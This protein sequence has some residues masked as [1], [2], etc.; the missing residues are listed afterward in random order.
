MQVLKHTIF[1][2]TLFFSVLTINTQAQCPDIYDYLGTPSASPE[3]F[4]CSGSNYT[5]NIQVSENVGAWTINWGDGSLI[6]SG[7][8]LNPSTLVSH[9]YGA[10]VATYD[11]TFTDIDDGCTVTGTLVMEEPSNATIQIPAGGITQSCAPQAMVFTNNSTNVSPNTVFTWDFGDGSDSET[12]DASNH[13]QTISHTYQSG[14][15]DCETVVTLTAQNLCNAVQGGPS[16]NTFGPIQVWNKDIAQIGVSSSSNCFPDNSFTFTNT[17]IRNCESSGNIN[18]RLEYWNFGD[19]WG[20]GSD[21]IVDWTAYP[22]SI[23]HQIDFPGVGSYNV[24]L[25][26]QNT[27]GTDTTDITVTIVNPPTSGLSATPTNVCTGNQVSFTNSSSNDANAYLINFDDGNGWAGIGPSDFTH[28]FNTVGSYNVGLAAY[29][30]GAIN[31]CSDTAWATVDVVAGPVS[32][33]TLSQTTSCGP[34]TIEFNNTSVDAVSYSWNLPSSITSNLIPAPLN[35]TTP[36]SYN[37][38]LEV[39]S[40]NNCTNTSTQTVTIYDPPVADFSFTTACDGDGVIFNNL[41]SSTDPIVSYNWDF[42]DGN[43]SNQENPQHTYSTSGS[44]D[45]VLTVTT[46][47]CSSDI[48]MSVSIAA[49][50]GA[51]FT[52]S[53]IEGCSPLTVDFNNTSVNADSYNW[54]MGDGSQTSIES[55]SNTFYNNTNIP[56]QFTVALYTNNAMGCADTIQ[57]VITVNPIPNANFTMQTGDA[58]EP[59][60]VDFVNLSTEATNYEWVLEPGVTSTD[61]STSYLYTNNT[62]NQIVYTPFLVAY[63]TFGCTDTSFQSVTTYPEPDFSF[64]LSPLSG[65][66]PLTVTMPNIAGAV[67]H[68]WNFGGGNTSTLESPNY[69]YVNNT[70][71]TLNYN[72]QLIASNSFGCTDTAMSVITIYPNSLSQFAPDFYTA[73]SP[74]EINFTDNST[75]GDSYSWQF[76]DGDIDAVLGDVSHTFINNGNAPMVFT[77]S[78]LVTSDHNCQSESSVNITVYPK[79]TSAFESDTVGCTPLNINFTNLSTEATSYFWNFG[80]GSPL[81]LNTNAAHEFINSTQADR[82]LEVYL[83]SNSMYGCRD[84]S[85]TTITVYPEAIA[86]FQTDVVQGCSPLDLDMINTTTPSS[87]YDWTYGDG[88]DEIN[89]DEIHGHIFHNDTSDSL[90]YTIDLLVTTNHGCTAT[91]RKQ[92][93][94]FPE[95]TASFVSPSTLCAGDDIVFTNTS[96]DAISYNW[97]FGDQGSSSNINPIHT[98]SNTTGETI[99]EPVLLTAQSS[100]GCQDVAL[101]L[102]HVYSMPIVDFTIDSTSVCYPLYVELANNSQYATDYYWDY[103][104]GTNSTV[105]DTIHSHIFTNPGQSL[106]T[107]TI[108]LTA[109]T[110]NGC[111]ATTTTNVQVIPELIASFDEVVS[112]C[113][114]LPME[115]N[116]T[117][118]GALEY[119]W[120]LDEDEITNEAQPSYTYLNYGVAE[121]IYEVSLVATSYFGCTDTLTQEFIVY[122]VP[123]AEFSVTP[124]VQLFPEATIEII[125]NSVYG[126]SSFTWDMGDGFTSDTAITTYTY[127][128]Y[129]IYFVNLLVDNGFCSDETTQRVEITP[130]SPIAMFEGE[131]E[132][133][134][135]ITIDFTNLSIYSD[136]YIWNFGDGSTSMEEN[137]SHMYEIPGNY[138][139]SLLVTGPGG[140]DVILQEGII[141]VYPHAV[142]EFNINPPTVQTGV[143]V[144]FYNTSQN[145]GIYEWNFGEGTTSTE[146][147]PTFTYTTPGVY[148]ITLI[149]NNEHNCPDS[150]FIEGALE[151]EIG[152]FIN[153]PNAFT[154]NQIGPVDELYDPE[155]LDNDVFHPVFEGVDKYN[156]QIYNRW[157][158]LL[159][160]TDD[161]RRGWNGYFEGELVPLGV[162]VWRVDVTFTDNKQFVKSGDI[163]LLR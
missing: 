41:S 85:S 76:G 26:V 152:G 117:S 4:E 22:P 135:P 70:P 156:L 101:G 134:S 141:H 32:A 83:V 17:S 108:E 116:N 80:D 106:L 82:E 127:D 9:T 103:D 43:S 57:Q 145:A 84:T 151:V 86:S 140:N 53:S 55:P 38:S 78:L 115:F 162:Y 37:I 24:M 66:S 44:Y 21:S 58:C 81:N 105:M 20:T 119:L 147:N 27:C 93:K 69:A 89:N 51:S 154:P 163:T 64:D 131:G 100:F 35:L 114:P 34:A 124:A 11:I 110:A 97:N 122:P 118:I 72:V 45:V 148:D 73:C 7:A 158:E 61:N 159:F 8:A 112:A 121:E 40:L 29:V 137:P 1:G 88:D 68:H 60:A 47:N 95:L 36:G 92:V 39:T 136:S 99:I 133:C 59:V 56:Q 146:S 65:C 50:A 48:T 63:N 126:E 14:T 87:T 25:I 12:Y 161:T 16:E 62:A 67:N 23:P 123:D 19:Y 149:A 6:E 125:D 75:L 160:E 109:T 2:L 102:V 49:G 129:G 128:T 79:V 104:D 74:A 107:N 10:S 120:T 111:S 3:W 94:V 132:G 113:H 71:D 98:F 138:T 42:G 31:T 13:L 30:S 18:N 143:P 28:V 33:F 77:T 130:P 15:I 144:F 5:L 139:V 150:L 96:E 46:A 153:F 54:Y 90:S 52:A 157:G 91:D 155:T 142:A